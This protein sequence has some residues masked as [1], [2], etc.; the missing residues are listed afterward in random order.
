MRL[1]QRIRPRLD[2]FVAAVRD[3]ALFVQNGQRG[4]WVGDDKLCLAI[5][6]NPEFAYLFD[7]TDLGLLKQHVPW[8]RN[9][10]LLNAERLE[11]IRGERERYELKRGLDTRGMGVFVGSGVDEARWQAA[12]DVA[13]EEAWLVQEFHAT[14]WIQRDFDSPETQR[15]DLALGAI[16]GELTTLFMRSSGELRVNMAMAGRMHPVFLGS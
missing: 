6:S 16:N 12:V 13:V 14:T 1:F 4:R 5:I 10:R 15:H 7:E 9:A 3:R 11:A 2:A 8:S